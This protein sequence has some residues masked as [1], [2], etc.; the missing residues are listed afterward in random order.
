DGQRL[1]VI[2]TLLI[3]AL[4]II[5]NAAQSVDMSLK[6]PG[7]LLYLIGNTRNELAGS[8][9]LEIVGYQTSRNH[10][11]GG[12]GE[13]EGREPLRS[14]SVPAIGAGTTIPYVDV[15]TARNT[16][17]AV[18]KAIRSGLALSCHDLSEGGLAVAAAEMALAGLLGLSIDIGQV[19]SE[20]LDYPDELLAIVLLFS[21][22]ASRFLL[23]VAPQQ[24]EE[25]EAHMRVHDVQ[26]ITCLGSVTENGRFHVRV[27]ERVL[28]DLAVDELQAAW[29]GETA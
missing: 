19:A 27:G 12:G 22:S 29:K 15:A 6:R 20:P 28:I 2:P 9:Y 18:G 17:N 1:P 11:K 13:E 7:N 25:F 16:M 21:E 4:S 5:D 10:S 8:H 14:P 23:E 24:R 26:D 3:S